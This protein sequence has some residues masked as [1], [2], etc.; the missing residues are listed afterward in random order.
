M[1]DSISGLT[2]E[3]GIQWACSHLEQHISPASNLTSRL[4][5]T[6]RHAG[7]RQQSLKEKILTFSFE[8]NLNIY[9]STEHSDLLIIDLIRDWFQ[10][11][12]LAFCLLHFTFINILNLNPLHTTR[13][14]QATPSPTHYFHYLIL[15]PGQFGN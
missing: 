10:S 8:R 2:L 5:W 1:S 6:F 4:R 12:Y 9:S 11:V 3:R 15:T 13:L 7:M 14:N